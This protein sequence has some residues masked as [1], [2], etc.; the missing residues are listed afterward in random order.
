MYGALTANDGFCGVMPAAALNLSQPVRVKL[1]G[2]DIDNCHHSVSVFRGKAARLDFA[3][4][5]GILA[6]SL[7]GDKFFFEG[8]TSFRKKL[9]ISVQLILQGWVCQGGIWC[10]Y[11]GSSLK[12]KQVI[13]TG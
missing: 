9:N 8:F 12:I 10:L 2:M 13:P 6:F 1:V 11:W 7:A 4:G 3:A 5:S